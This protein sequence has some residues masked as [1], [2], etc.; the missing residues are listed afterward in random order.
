MHRMGEEAGVGLPGKEDG[1]AEAR[2]MRAVARGD[3]AAFGALYDRYGS[4]VYSFCLR[5]L[6]DPGAAE[7]AAQEAFI[8]IWR[9]AGTFD[10]RRGSLRPWLLTV[11]H[12]CCLDRLRERRREAEPLDPE[13]A[14]EVADA[15]SSPEDEAAR[16]EQARRV[17]SALAALAPDQ[18]RALTLM[19]YGGY[20]QS[21]ISA[22]LGLPLGTV[23]SRTRLGLQ[24][25]R[26]LLQE[27]GTGRGDLA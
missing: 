24:A 8:R 11:V 17:R 21:E 13:T 12:R 22:A 20:S 7:E 26:R 6:R 9:G 2:L 3:L 4:L 23:K 25:M 27:R 19:Y 14:A 18:R 10:P 15:G 16:G 5:L 1:A